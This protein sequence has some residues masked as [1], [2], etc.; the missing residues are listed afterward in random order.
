MSETHISS[1]LED[2]S[3]SI[4]DEFH[5]LSRISD[6]SGLGIILFSQDMGLEYCNDIAL[7]LFEIPERFLEDN[8]SYN[9]LILQMAKRGDFGAGDSQ[10]FVAHITDILNNQKKAGDGNIAELKLTVPSGRRLLVR[11]KY[12]SDSRLLLTTEDITLEERASHT[13]DIA[14][15]SGGSG[16]WYYNYETGEISMHGEYLEKHL[17]HRKMA[18]S[19]THLT[20]PTILLV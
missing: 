18:V 11:Q 13:L 19:Y 4:R 17:S 16:F 14:L 10:S 8:V 12:D 15:E 7:E 20:L 5:W 1:D 2:A 6:V 3:P 9:E